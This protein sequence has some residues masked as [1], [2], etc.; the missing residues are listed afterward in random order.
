MSLFRTD[1]PMMAGM[2]L[3][4]SPLAAAILLSAWLAAGTSAAA[5]RLRVGSVDKVENQAEIVSAGVKTSA[6]RG[7]PVHLNDE[8]RTGPEGRLQVVFADDSILTL[9]EKASVRIDRYV[10]DPGANAGETVLTAARGAFRFA[11]GRIKQ[12]K[13]SSIS[14]ATP[15]A[16][17]GVRGTEFWGGPIDAAYGVLLLEGEIVVTNR[18]GS[19]TLASRGEGTDIASAD[20]APG[21]VKAWGD[22]KIARAVASVAL[23]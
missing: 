5:E 16:V 7:A 20:E 2:A 10:Y 8:L 12:L 18:A 23:H 15:V 17:I 9:G 4:P 11:S 19:V 13:Q 1:F 6:A 22:A 14:V 3:W 21:P